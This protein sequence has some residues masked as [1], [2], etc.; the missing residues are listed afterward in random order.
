MMLRDYQQKVSDL[1]DDAMARGKRSLAVMVPTG[2]GKTHI[3]SHRAK[4]AGCQTVDIAHRQEL[5]Y[6]ISMALA[7]DGVTH[8][9]LAPD[10]VAN[11][12][13]K[14]QHHAFGRSYVDGGA[15]HT[16]A[17]VDTIISRMDDLGNWPKQVGLA[18]IDEAHHVVGGKD[19]P[20]P[21]KWA[22]GLSI[23]PNARV[24]GWS[25]TWGRA[26]R[27]PLTFF[28]E[29]IFGPTVAELME[30]GF[31]CKY[32]IYGPPPSIDLST[33]PVTASGD[34][35]PAKLAEAA[36]GERS[37][38]VGD[39]IQHY[40]KLT[41]GMVGLA[42][43]VDVALAKET[44]E[45]FNA[46]AGSQVAVWMSARETNDAVRQGNIEK[47][48]RGDIKLI[49]NVDL[50]GEG[51]DVPRV[52]VILD[53]APTESLSRYL[54]RFGRLLRPSPGKD[55]GYYCDLVGNVMRHGLPD[56][57]RHWSLEQP[58]K[59]KRTPNDETA[60]KAC[61]ECF[62]VFEVFLPAC[63]HCGWRPV[64]REGGARRPEEVD[65]DLLL[66]SE[67]LLASMRA[68]A[69]EIVGP[70]PA[71]SNTH[72]VNAW[73][74]RAMVQ[75][76]LRRSIDQWAGVQHAK[77]MEMG[78]I[79]RLFWHRFGIDTGT[80]ATLGRPQ[81]VA[82]DAK[83]W[84]DINNGCAR[85]KDAGPV[86]AVV[87]ERDEAD[88]IDGVKP[89][90]NDERNRWLVGVK[91][92]NGDGERIDYPFKKEE[93]AWKAARWVKDNPGK[94]LPKYLDKREIKEKKGEFRAY[95]NKKHIGYFK[96]EKEK[97]EAI[98]KYRKKHNLGPQRKPKGNGGKIQCN[99]YDRNL[100]K[101][102]NLGRFNSHDEKLKAQDNYRKLHNLPRKFTKVKAN[103]D[104]D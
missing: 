27:K 38:I 35:S 14:R 64:P 5:V 69:A 95:V 18:Q 42:F 33:V 21:N 3:I 94:L 28:E 25:A 53:G 52:E 59:R 45:R 83:I 77:G 1:I 58:E 99:I 103:E 85:P 62:Q 20:E 7:R 98:E 48:A 47:L 32:Q 54:Q 93:M 50:L 34:F 73:D 2:G 100:R 36:H 101:T 68:R 72:A 89:R 15:P 87:V 90:W 22:R 81:A 96:S 86:P 55:M 44:A 74:Q 65:G 71:G 80:A 102:V 67:E 24:I 66:Y 56:Q 70:A 23:F 16:V 92:P 63:P 78:A 60:L 10:N 30:R 13:V 4:I 39:M 9:I 104:R 88:K 82:L 29:L 11:Y 17:S 6:Q 31:L 26:D 12:I 8:R 61:P 76:H 46:A 75:E 43:C 19:N 49:C 84:E 40:G 41:P 51:V 97:L 91:K 37:T 79:Y 57:P